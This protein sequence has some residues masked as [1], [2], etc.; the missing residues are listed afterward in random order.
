M[1]TSKQAILPNSR[2]EVDIH[3]DLDAIAALAIAEGAVQA[4]P[5]SADSIIVDERVSM[6]CMS[7][8]IYGTS[9]QCPPNTPD[10]ETFRRYVSRYDHG[11]IFRVEGQAQAGESGFAARRRESRGETADLP[12]ADE[13]RHRIRGLWQKLHGL[14]MKLE[15]ASFN[16]GYYLVR[17]LL[18]GRCGLCDVC[19]VGGECR[20][21][22]EARPSMEACGIDVVRSTKSVGWEVKFPAD[23]NK[24]SFVG[25]LLVA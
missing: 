24:I 18:A 19:N 12:E 23:P 5:I 22:T 7:C 17:G 9:L 21:P 4:T 16:R 6:M 10:A 20:H 2:P 25:L 15:G 14:C 11:V 1:S 13:P 8:P 3:A